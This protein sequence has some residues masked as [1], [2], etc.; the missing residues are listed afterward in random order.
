MKKIILDSET[1]TLKRHKHR[2]CDFCST[3]NVECV[4]GQMITIWRHEGLFARKD[5][6]TPAS[7]CKDCVTQIHNLWKN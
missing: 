6:E 3:S 5:I 2:K 1:I 7:I 4:D